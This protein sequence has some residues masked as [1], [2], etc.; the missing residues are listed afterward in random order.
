[1]KEEYI[2]GVIGLDSREETTQPVSTES[3]S[4]KYS[5]QLLPNYFSESYDAIYLTFDS[6]AKQEAVRLQFRPYMTWF[7]RRPDGVHCEHK[8]DTGPSS[9]EGSK[10]GER[11][12]KKSEGKGKK[13]GEGRQGDHLSNTDSDSFQS[14][15]LIL[16]S[17]HSSKNDWSLLCTISDLCSLHTPSHSHA[18][19]CGGLGSLGSDLGSLGSDPTPCGV[20][21]DEN[22]SRIAQIS[23]KNG[24]PTDLVFHDAPT[25]SS[26]LSLLEGYYTLIEKSN[27]SICDSVVSPSMVRLKSLKCHGPVGRS[28]THNKLKFKL[29]HTFDANPTSGANSVSGANSAS[30][31]NSFGFYT[32]RMDDDDFDT[33]ILE[34]LG[35]DDG[36]LL[37]ESIKIEHGVSY[38]VEKSS[39]RISFD[40][41]PD[42]ITYI[43]SEIFGFSLKSCIRPSEN[44][45]R[46]KLLLSRSSSDA[47]QLYSKSDAIDVS[48]KHQILVSPSGVNYESSE[49]LLRSNRFNV[50]TGVL[51]KQIIVSK[52]LLEL[53]SDL[54]WFNQVTSA[55]SSARHSALLSIHGIVNFPPT[56]ITEY[57]PLGRLDQFLIANE[58]K[59]QTVDLI[60][61]AECLAHALFYLNED[62]KLIHGSIRCHNLLVSSYTPSCLSVKLSDPFFDFDENILQSEALAFISPELINNYKRHLDS[63]GSSNNFNRQNTHQHFVSSYDSIVGDKSAHAQPQSQGSYQNSNST[64]RNA[65]SLSHTPSLSH[66]QLLSLLTSFEGDVWAFGTTVWQIFHK[67]RKP[68]ATPVGCCGNIATTPV[69]SPAIDDL[70]PEPCPKTCPETIWSLIRKR[71]WNVD[72]NDRITPRKI[73]KKLSD[74]LYEIYNQKRGNDYTSLNPITLKSSHL[75]SYQNTR[76]NCHIPNPR[77]GSKIPNPRYNPRYGSKFY[78][79]LKETFTSTSGSSLL[80]TTTLATDLN[81]PYTYNLSTDTFLTDV[82]TLTPIPG[83]SSTRS[84]VSFVGEQGGE[85]RGEGEGDTEEGE[86]EEGT[87]EGAGF[88]EKWIIDVNQLSSDKT[89]LL[90]QVSLLLH[91]SA[92]LFTA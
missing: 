89:I 47:N 4:V 56:L 51:S 36:A 6:D 28:F 62:A 46:D 61:A 75:P 90:G 50:R 7:R 49:T 85:G 83:P 8:P 72:V 42:A 69:P 79:R 82:S 39:G 10:S 70:C 92:F 38:L 87:G 24:I 45:S 1:M 60:Q 59:L 71:C 65:H 21:R 57:L 2:K 33:I 17:K 37:S 78:N 14:N 86:G 16:K 15:C 40:T 68:L 81:Y 26:F 23:R 80:S 20:L 55:W 74:T 76:S 25:L 11:K 77:Y 31:A 84:L 29:E 63:Q 66:S 43:G 18:T 3:D 41:L 88:D 35:V 52:E 48:N 53:D 19:P 27:F 67:G 5:D 54:L 12:G 13:S 22:V 91:F 9:A 64:L 44:D 32:L 30:G 73:V 34:T 58:F